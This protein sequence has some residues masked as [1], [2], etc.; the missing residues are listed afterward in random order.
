MGMYTRKT[1]YTSLLSIA[2]TAALSGTTYAQDREER[3]AAAAEVNAPASPSATPVASTTSASKPTVIETV[4]QAYV[5]SIILPDISPS[6]ATEIS[7]LEEKLLDQI[8]NNE[9]DKVLQLWNSQLSI[10]KTYE[11]V[12]KAIGKKAQEAYES[13]AGD[14]GAKRAAKGKAELRA[15]TD[16]FSSVD[17]GLGGA[18]LHTAYD[19]FCNVD[20]S[21]K[22]KTAN[23][24]T[25]AILCPTLELLDR[26]I[27]SHKNRMPDD[28]TSE[29]KKQY[30]KN[31]ELRARDARRAAI[32]LAVYVAY[33]QQHS[34]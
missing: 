31:A 32:V 10:S 6:E 1:G 28:L 15:L 8:R 26:A 18:E 3:R 14:D 2:L 13:A 21:G 12:G 29:N 25:T 5:P 17:N 9:P 16:W 20:L 11:P 34:N 19:R 22:N 4:I 30:Q 33:T 24:S 7:A 23:V 27:E